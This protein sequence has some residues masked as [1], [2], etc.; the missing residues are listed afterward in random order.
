MGTRKAMA[1]MAECP[2]EALRSDLPAPAKVVL[3][4]LWSYA[5]RDA[6]FVWPSRE[7]L[8]AE[9]G[10]KS[11]RTLRTHLRRLERDRWIVQ[12][13]GTN[14][15]MGWCLCDPPGD[16]VHAAE[17]E[18]DAT[19]DRPA[20]SG[21]TP[22]ESGQRA[23]SGHEPRPEVATEPA[24]YG[25]SHLS[26]GT[27]HEPITPPPN[28][29]PTV[30]AAPAGAQAGAGI[31]ASAWCSDFRFTWEDRFFKCRNIIQNPTRNPRRLMELQAALDEFGAD[32][33]RD[34]LLWAGGEVVR[35]FESKGRFGVSPGSL[36]VAF[37]AEAPSFG[38]LL[39]GWQREQ[40]R[41]R[42]SGRRRA[43]PG[44]LD[45]VPLSDEE[46]RVWMREGSEHEAEDAVR[47]HRAQALTEASAVQWDDG[48]GFG[49]GAA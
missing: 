33:V 29:T 20:T 42:V 25:H 27:N 36:S 35:H 5:G 17:I 10:V 24:E 49:E 12:R 26:I 32:T 39:D 22:A 48:L 21:Q 14:G 4:V 30:Q 41:K 28:S 43:A 19:H 16:V 6:R 40:G 23:E 2:R 1:P 45:G 46:Q 15:R 44:E 7:T 34:V 37:R 3:A 38:V 11:E 13:K 31:G 8:R 47:D 18:P 9:A